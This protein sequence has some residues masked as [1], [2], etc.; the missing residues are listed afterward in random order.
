MNGSSMI[1]VKAA[2]AGYRSKEA[3]ARESVRIFRI[4][5][6]QAAFTDGAELQSPSIRGSKFLL[7]Y[8]CRRKAVANIMTRTALLRS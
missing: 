5:L 1:V 6:L 2:M 3:S 7:F 4:N 8:L